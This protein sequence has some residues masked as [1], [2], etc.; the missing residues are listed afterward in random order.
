MN[1]LTIK[2][3]GGF[4]FDKY[5][6]EKKNFQYD[7]ILFAIKN[8]LMFI[9]TFLFPCKYLIFNYLTLQQGVFIKIKKTGFEFLYAN[10][11]NKKAFHF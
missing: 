5:I 7:F 8:G 10:F 6:K 9:N 1:Y 4:F 3:L 11:K 2:S